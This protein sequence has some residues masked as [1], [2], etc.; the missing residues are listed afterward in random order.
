MVAVGVL[1]FTFNDEFLAI[2]PEAYLTLPNVAFRPNLP[3][4]VLGSYTNSSIINFECSVNS[5]LVS[6][7]NSMPTLPLPVFTVSYEKTSRSSSSEI[8]LS[9]SF[10]SI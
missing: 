1:I 9:P 7:I 10:L 2:C 4:F 6:S 3:V 8:P 5:T